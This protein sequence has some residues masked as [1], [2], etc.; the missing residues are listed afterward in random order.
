MIA[1]HRRALLLTLL[2][3]VLSG[4]GPAARAQQQQ[5]LRRSKIPVVFPEFRDARINQTFGRHTT[6][7]VNI[8]LDDGALYFLD[9]QEQVRRAY[10]DNVLSVDIDSVRYMKV[11]TLFG[12]LLA[13]QNY[14]CLVRVTLIDKKLYDSEAQALN[15]M[16][17]NG[18]GFFKESILEMEAEHEAGYPLKDVFYFIVKGRPVLA[19]ESY[20]KKLIAPDYKLAFKT[21]MADR[22]WSWRDPESLKRLLMYFP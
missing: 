1:S 13:E 9:E 6:A 5:E 15:D 20:V 8:F 12:Q 2:L 18:A 7:R 10:V 14:N 3:C 16:R 22:W 17:I 4:L 19:R 21:L 11:D